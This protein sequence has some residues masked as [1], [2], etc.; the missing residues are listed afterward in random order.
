MGRRGRNRDRR[1]QILAKIEEADPELHAELVALRSVNPQA[2]RKRLRYWVQYYPIDQPQKVMANR[3]AKYKGQQV[4]TLDGLHLPFQIFR[5]AVR[6]GNFDD[7]L[8][9]LERLERE[10]RNRPVIFQILQN[11]RDA[12]RAEPPPRV[13]PRERRSSWRDGD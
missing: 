2:Y 9:E 10:G 12:L 13:L 3:G 4:D 1:D 11:R 6:A 5:N 7:R 8:D